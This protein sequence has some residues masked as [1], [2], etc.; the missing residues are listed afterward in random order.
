[1][2]DGRPAANAQSSDQRVEQLLALNK[3]AVEITGELELDD[4]LQRIVDAATDM[5]RCPHAATALTNAGLH[6]ENVRALELARWERAR[7]DALF[8][9]SQAI[10]RSVH[11]DEVI[12]LILQS[13]VELLGAAGAAVYLLEQGGPE[14]SKQIADGGSQ[15]FVA[16]YA[17][18]LEQSLTLESGQ[19]PVEGS[20]AGRALKSGVTE[21]VR[22]TA[23][24]RWMVFPR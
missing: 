24:E 9:V 3:A 12:E 8:G 5:L 18:G 7:A 22:D 2:D 17:V 21:V 16:R 1:M 10:N 19:L 6:A 15:R 11:L 14:G 4:L 20:L 13:T 23:E